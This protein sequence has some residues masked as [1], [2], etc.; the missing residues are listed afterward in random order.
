MFQRILP[1][2]STGGNIGVGCCAGLGGAGCY[3]GGSISE[4]C[5]LD[6]DK[7]EQEEGDDHRALAAIRACSSTSS[8]QV[9]YENRFLFVSDE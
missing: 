8:C 9:D 5:S 6:T 7:S 3:G 2:S 4:R 1:P